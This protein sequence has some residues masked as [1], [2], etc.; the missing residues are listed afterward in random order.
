MLSLAGLD[1]EPEDALVLLERTEGWPAGLYL[2]ALSLDGHQ[3]V[4]RA[5]ARFGGDDR[6]LADYVRDE[7]LVRLDAE[8]L[9]FLEETSVLD[10]LSGAAVRRG[11][12]SPRVRQGAARHVALEPARRPAR[13]RGRVLPLSPAPRR[14]APGGA[15]SRATAVRGRAAPAGERLVR[16]G[17]R[18]R[19]CD[20]P[21]DRRRRRRAR[22]RAAVGHGRSGVRRP[23]RR[24]SPPARA[25]HAR[26]DRR[27]SDARA[28]GRV[29]APREGRAR[30]DRALDRGRRAA[31]QRIG[32]RVAVRR[33]RDHAR[34]RR[35][36]TASTRWCPTPRARTG[37]RPRTARGG[38]SAACCAAS[39]S[40]CGATLAT[41]RTHLEEGARRGAIAAPSVQ[42]LCLAQLALLALDDGDWEQGP[43]LAARARAQVER[44]G[45]ERHPA[46]AL[47]FAVSA[48]VRAHRERV[49][50][51]QAD[52]R[53][54]VERP[55]LSRRL[56]PLVRRRGPGRAR[57]R[58]AP[59]RGRD[60]H[61]DAAGRGVE[62]A[63]ARARRRWSCA[64]G[65]TS[66][67]ARSRRSR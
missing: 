67:G 49:E 26:G 51:A 35:P 64:A 4:H 43:L 12:G 23:R 40:T 14:H 44:F 22:R 24:G 1:L 29:P 16:A 18:R 57:P 46:A 32:A 50:D 2:A 54:A 52:R 19:S 38:R 30:P 7:L 59:P 56:R 61:A 45:S 47:V 33:H 10:E 42:S 60:G 28:H 53:R 15:A 48:L 11:P 20:R 55:D 9:A 39:A 62:G 21:R 3:D 6:L 37:A 41:A 8:Q 31:P 34:G 36:S 27:P 17:R 13:R 65:S 66:S 25:L 5:V 63:V 58:G